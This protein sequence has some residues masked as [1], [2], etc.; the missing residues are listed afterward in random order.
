MDEVYT[1][2]QQSV[3]WKKPNYISADAFVI[4]SFMYP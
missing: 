1:L 3:L 4:H 2:C